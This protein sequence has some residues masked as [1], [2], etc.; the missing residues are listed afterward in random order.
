MEEALKQQLFWLV[1]L[2]G[3]DIAGIGVTLTGMV[4]R[5]SSYIKRGLLT[6]MFSGLAAIPYYYAGME[7][8]TALPS[9]NRPTGLHNFELDFYTVLAVTFF[10]S[11]S[12]L[13]IYLIQKSAGKI[14]KFILI[15]FI[16]FGSVVTVYLGWTLLS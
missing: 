11:F 5:Q 4:K 3:L 13:A 10:F 8:I 15:S 2:T 16:T 1:V 12:A 9:G 7:V 6:V 14:P